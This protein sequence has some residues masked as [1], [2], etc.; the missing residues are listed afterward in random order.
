MAPLY[1]LLLINEIHGG[2]YVRIESGSCH[3]YQ[4]VGLCTISDL[5]IWVVFDRNTEKAEICELNG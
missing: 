1:Y 3:D 4:H 2:S 5:G